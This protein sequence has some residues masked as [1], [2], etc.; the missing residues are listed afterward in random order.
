MI[1]QS[2]YKN[3]PIHFISFVVSGKYIRGRKPQ[4]YFVGL[5]MED[6]GR[7]CMI[8]A[9]GAILDTDMYTPIR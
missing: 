7:Q 5:Q 4:V 8:V 1:S 3:K 6:R 2:R 9:S